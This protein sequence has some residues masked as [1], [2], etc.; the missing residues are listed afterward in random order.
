[1]VLVSVSSA[2]LSKVEQGK[3]K[4]PFEWGNLIKSLYNLE[5][6]KKKELD[7]LIFNARNIDSIDISSFGQEEKDMMLL[8]A[9][10][11]NSID[12]KQFKDLL[13]NDEED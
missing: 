3:K 8:F 11:I 6:S 13:M 5:N 1:M 9:R 2:F 12:K 10:R 4:P 7:N